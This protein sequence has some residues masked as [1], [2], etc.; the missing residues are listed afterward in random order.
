MLRTFNCGIGMILVVAP[1]HA[2]A[3][4]DLLHQESEL[5]V[6]L[7]AIEP[8]DG[9]NCPSGTKDTPR[10]CACATNSSNIARHTPP[11]DSAWMVMT[12]SRS[13]RRRDIMCSLK[14]RSVTPS[15]PRISSYVGS[16]TGICGCDR[17]SPFTTG[18]KM[19][20]P[21]QSLL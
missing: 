14:F 20:S 10:L 3:V 15:R 5:V 18:R 6:D 16:V 12:L 4:T 19:L 13:G 9:N 1:E 7:G 8:A 2:T 11:S 21:L 17:H